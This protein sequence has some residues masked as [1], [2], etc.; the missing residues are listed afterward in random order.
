MEEN[1][2]TEFG[3]RR[4]PI[5]HKYKGELQ[6]CQEALHTSETEKRVWRM[7]CMGTA[8]LALVM[9]FCLLSA[10]RGNS[11]LQSKANGISLRVPLK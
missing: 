1:N 4:N 9:A 10:L 2:T 8:F 6:L 5:R 7:V 3:T 11:A